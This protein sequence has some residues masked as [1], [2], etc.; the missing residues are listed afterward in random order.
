M[1]KG[2]HEGRHWRLIDLP[3]R[4]LGSHGWGADYRYVLTVTGRRTGR[5]YSTPV[6]VMR[7]NGRRYLVAMAP[8][9]SWVRNVRASDMVGLDRGPRHERLGVREVG[10]QEAAPVLREYVRQIR[11]TRH[12]FDASPEDPLEAF[13]REAARHPVFELVDPP[14]T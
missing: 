14:V 1:A 7:C 9:A 5:P 3:F 4:W 6:D 2:Y 8:T 13:E 11:V 12:L 10:Q